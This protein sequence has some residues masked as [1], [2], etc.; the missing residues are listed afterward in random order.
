MR[1]FRANGEVVDDA[2]DEEDGDFTLRTTLPT[3]AE[4][5]LACDEMVRCIPGIKDQSKW[6]V[7]LEDL[8]VLA[9]K[10]VKR[11]V[12][13]ADEQASDANA[14][15]AGRTFFQLRLVPKSAGTVQKLDAT[16]PQI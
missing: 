1:K 7:E 14:T 13:Q 4:S 5:R 11:I 9:R 2:S 10:D 6:E 8:A 15:Q 16:D 12:E 3:A